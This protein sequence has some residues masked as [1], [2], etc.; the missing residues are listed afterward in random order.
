[1]A[2]ILDIIAPW[3]VDSWLAA[4]GAFAFSL[5]T[6][7]IE[8][9]LAVCVLAG[10][11]AALM[12]LALMGIGH[13]PWVARRAALLVLLPLV[14]LP[15]LAAGGTRYG[16]QA[17][18]EARRIGFVLLHGAQPRGRLQT[19]RV[20]PGPAI[21][22]AP[23]PVTVA[24]P[25][26]AG[27]QKTAEPVTVAPAV[28]EPQSVAVIEKPS[29]AQSAANAISRVA[30]LLARKAQ[31]RSEV[32]VIP[33]LFGTDRAAERG[34]KGLDYSAERSG[35]LALGRVLVTVPDAGR[36]EGDGP[37]AISEVKELAPDEVGAAA[38]L[39]ASSARRA[40]GR[41][42]VYVHGLNTSF[43]A[44]VLEAVRIAEA[45]RFDGAVLVY[46]WPSAGFVVRYAYD[47]Q[48]AAE[49]EPHLVDFLAFVARET[50]GS[51]IS[52][53]ADGLGAAAVVEAL[54]GHV[55]LTRPSEGVAAAIS[56]LVLR[57][58][59]MDQARFAAKVGALKPHIGKVTLY[60]T[61]SDRALNVSRRYVGAAP[62]AGDVMDGGPAVLD[63]V[64]TVDVT[65]PPFDPKAPKARAGGP[66]F[67]VL[68]Q[69]LGAGE[70]PGH[71]LLEAVQTARGAYW[72]LKANR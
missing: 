55:E 24:P 13:L 44:A 63:G 61:A 65:E 41:A 25:V 54:E 60:A 34:G 66:A 39:E 10:A 51:P 67:A 49:T 56:D 3:I 5:P 53:V 52:I 12:V 50:G 33:V 72:R 7:E 35:R 43:R 38:R 19:A 62:R 47:A 28:A 32:R 42:L 68:G 15:L 9:D 29:S 22:A 18:V 17:R 11:V 26:P 48:S 21:A 2:V 58:P 57:A 37:G 23:K 20:E 46:S 69:R 45:A 14:A 6:V 27:E 40:K 16:L 4:F 70:A 1:M 71:E 8:R 64:E 30:S 31:P 36:G 59:D